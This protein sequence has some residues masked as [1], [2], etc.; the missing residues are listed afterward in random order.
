M[1]LGAAAGLALWWLLRFLLHRL[2]RPGG[3]A[4]DAVLYTLLP[5]LLLAGAM[6]ALAIGYRNI[7]HRQGGAGRALPVAEAYA[8]VFN[9][10][11]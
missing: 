7:R 9:P 3:I 8:R 6:T 2:R 5:I 11:P 4:I 10:A 1:L